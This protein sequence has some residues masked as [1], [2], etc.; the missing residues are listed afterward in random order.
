[1]TLKQG[2]IVVLHVDNINYIHY[3]LGLNMNIDSYTVVLL[4]GGFNL[5]SLVFLE[6]YYDLLNHS[7]CAELCG[8]I[9]DFPL[10]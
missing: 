10:W 1:M 2:D 6:N 9:S 5:C 4:I 7:Y 3:K 8:Y